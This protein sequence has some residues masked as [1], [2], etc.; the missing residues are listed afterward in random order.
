MLR[1]MSVEDYAKV[2]DYAIL[3]PSTQ[4]KAIRESCEIAKKYNFAAFYTTPCWT[5]I[6]SKE[7]K[8]SGVR[9]GSAIGFPYGTT[10]SK[11]KL[12]EIEESLKLGCTAIDM[13][14]NIGALKDKNYKLVKNEIKEL[15]NMCEDKAL[16]KVIFEVCFLSDEEIIELTKICSELGVDYVKTA[17]GSQGFPTYSQVKLMLENVSGNTKVKVSGVPRTFTLGAT[18]FML[19]I[20]VKLIGTRSAPK[21]V[22]AYREYIKTLNK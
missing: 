21:L 12:L 4:E 9:S 6:T 20:G 11:S 15:V 7:L 10:F 19:D 16:A 5:H 14:V 3:N 18:L 13:V 17:T 8:G 1:S 22:D 2:F